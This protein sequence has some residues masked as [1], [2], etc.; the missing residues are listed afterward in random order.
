MFVVREVMHCTP[1]KVGEM[2]KK[3]KALATVMEE[4]GL[5]PFRLLTDVSGERFWTL[6]IEGEFGDVGEFLDLQARVMADERAQEAM[7]GY[8][9]LVDSGRREIYKVEA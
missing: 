2:V 1:G 9:D 5:E 6:V 7:S 3:F 4:M 8:H